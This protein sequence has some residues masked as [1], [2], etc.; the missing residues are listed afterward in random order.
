MVNKQN[1]FEDTHSLVKDWCF[2][3]SKVPVHWAKIGASGCFFG[4]QAT[5]TRRYPFIGQILLVLRGVSLANTHHARIRSFIGQIRA[6][7]ILRDGSL[8]NTQHTHHLQQSS[9][10]LPIDARRHN[11]R[12]GQAVGEVSAERLNGRHGWRARSGPEGLTTSTATT[13]A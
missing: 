3:V 7:I 6:L 11:N 8:V 4:K 1:R 5:R 12:T 10:A 9:I 2:G 13:Y